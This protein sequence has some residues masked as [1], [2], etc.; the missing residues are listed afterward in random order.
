M[1]QKVP[2]RRQAKPDDTIHKCALSPS[3]MNGDPGY[4][5]YWSKEEVLNFLKEL[6]ES[7]RIG[8]R[9]FAEIGRG[10]PPC[11]GPRF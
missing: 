9:A 3:A 1:M 2:L 10:R 5:G 7:E 8:A 4:F 11:C 6:L